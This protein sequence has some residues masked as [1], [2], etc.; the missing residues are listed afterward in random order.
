[1]HTRTR[2]TWLTALF[3]ALALA[4]TACGDNGEQTTTDEA[5][6]DEAPSDEEADYNDADIMFLQGMIPHH[7]QAVEMAE[8]VPDRTDRPE[9]LSFA[10]E[11]IATQQAE[12][13]QMQTML[14][15]AGAAGSSDDHEGHGEE[16]DHDMAGMMTEEQMSELEGLEGVAFDV[17]FLDMMIEHHQGAVDSAESVIEEG[18]NPEVRAL[19]Q[20]IITAQQA[21]IDQMSEW[22]EQWGA[23]S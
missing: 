12:I 9:L 17:L 6:T 20:E 16:D 13:D 22:R 4:V 7:E 1:M 21:E 5:P 15:D 23:A 19:A 11:I 3:A 18:Q 2:R 10:E 14:D 8:W